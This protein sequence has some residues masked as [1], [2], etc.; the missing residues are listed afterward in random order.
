M[1]HNLEE[2]IMWNERILREQCVRS[3][4]FLEEEFGFELQENP[5]YFIQPIPYWGW[6]QFDRPDFRVGMMTEPIYWCYLIAVQQASTGAYVSLDMLLELRKR[7]TGEQ[8]PVVP[9]LVKA[10]LPDQ[11]PALS[12]EGK[13]HLAAY[14]AA[15][16]AK[17]RSVLGPDLGLLRQLID[18]L[19]TN[20]TIRD[21]VAKGRLVFTHDD[22]RPRLEDWRKRS[23][24]K[25]MG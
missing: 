18:L 10:G 25:A 20:P 9:D 5:D 1:N 3:F 12:E 24:P 22:L 11:R 8:I 7:M 15:K 17:L 2:P 4:R 6:V 14:A 19:T 23:L 16:A 21:E 13:A